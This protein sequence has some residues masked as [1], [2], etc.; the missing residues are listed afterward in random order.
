MGMKPFLDS[1]PA[2][3]KSIDDALTEAGKQAMMADRAYALRRA[4]DK[5]YFEI[6]PKKV[7][8]PPATTLWDKLGGEK[9]VTKV[10]DDF[11]ALAS[12]NPKVNFDRDGKYKFD[13]GAVTKLKRSL[14]EMISGATGGPLRYAGKSMKDVHKGMGITDAEFDA[15]VADLKKALADNKVKQED[16]DA[17]LK[18][19]EGTRKDIVEP[20]PEAPKEGEVKGKVNLDGKPLAKASVSLVPE[21]GDPIPAKTG[22]D[23]SFTSAK[24]PLGSYKVTVKSDTAGQVPAKYGDAKTTDLKVDVKAGA[25][26]PTFELKGEQKPPE[27]AKEGELSGTLTFDGKPLAKATLTLTP[28]SGEPATAKT[29]DDGKFTVAKLKPGSYVISI[30]S[31]VKLPEKY[32]DAK[33]SPLKTDVKEGKDNKATLDVKSEEKPEEAKTS[34]VTGK[35]TL[36]DKPVSGATV[37][38]MPVKGNPIL[39]TIKDDGTFSV[40]KVPVGKYKIAVVSLPEPKPD[41]TKPAVKIPGKYADP[42]KSEI[43]FE[44][45]EDKN[46]LN[47]KLV[48]K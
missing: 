15:T 26:S 28:A 11:T 16:A 47:L 9:G 37:L 18:I 12:K 44:V 48:S 13:A 27:P 30:K 31:D 7:D 3:T 34:K 39:G 36:D 32:G 14:V 41:P 17:L 33:T 35:A 24:V 19:V 6:N 8:P 43:S 20:K 10:V 23:G 46:E 45:K 5:I 2:W 42:E 29:D 4:M 25:N 21:K 40:D 38:F 1:K 22:D